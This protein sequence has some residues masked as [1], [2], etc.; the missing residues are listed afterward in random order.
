MKR[1]FE[2]I[3]LIS[4]LVFSFFLT[5]KTSTVIKN[6]DDIMVMIKSNKKNYETKSI[7]AHINGNSIIP[8]ISKKEVN[9]NKSYS[10]MKEYGKYNSNL[11]IYNYTK[12][13]IS[14]TN[15]KDKYITRGNV[16]KRMV[17]L[18]FI[19]DDNTN[20]DKLLNILNNNKVS[21]ALF[22]DEEYLSNNLDL[23]Y[24]LINN[25]Y[26]IGIKNNKSNYK[27]MDTIITK[28]GKQ[29]NI[30][31]LYDNKDT[32]DNCININ[33][34]TIKGIKINKNYYS[35]IK[36]ELTSGA[37]FNLDITDELINNLDVIIKFIKKKGYSIE[38]IDIH[39]KE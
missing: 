4:L 21:S 30:Y 17:S 38:N 8:G 20:L 6:L 33:G 5:D 31:C 10:K 23:I 32:I 16:I 37:I 12:P 25:G 28:I 34:Y 39:I 18:N 29:K 14:I 15:N 9:V 11:Y 1:L 22:I 2:R 24:S 36:K 27:W 13:N 19:I 7:N 35:N 3:G 26:I